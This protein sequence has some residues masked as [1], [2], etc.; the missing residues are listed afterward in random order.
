MVDVDGQITVPLAGSGERRSTVT[1]P[2]LVGVQVGSPAVAAVAAAGRASTLRSGLPGPVGAS[3][4][5]PVGNP[6]RWGIAGLAVARAEQ[7]SGGVASSLDEARSLSVQ[8]T[9]AP[10]AAAPWQTVVV[11]GGLVTMDLSWVRPLRDGAAEQVAADLTGETVS[12]WSSD[13]QAP[14]SQAAQS[15]LAGLGAASSPE[16]FARQVATQVQTWVVSSLRSADIS[17]NSQMADAMQVRIEL[18]GQDVSIHFRTDV[19]GTREVMA[20]QLDRLQGLLQA[21]G[22]NLADTSFG[23]FGQQERQGNGSSFTPTEAMGRTSEP[24]AIR[25]PV[26]ALPRSGPAQGGRVGALDVFV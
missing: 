4:S 21:Q 10:A 17:L 23:D 1:D 12:A 5:G 8:P 19:V 16:A 2:M 7:T 9:L 13:V 20:Q 24:S 6:L 14:V 25:T 11:S 22:L 26:A 18:Q 15:G 3:M